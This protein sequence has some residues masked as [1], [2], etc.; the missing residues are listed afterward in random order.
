MASLGTKRRPAIVRVQTEPR[1][2]QL[3]ELCEANDIQVIIGLEPD[4]PEDITDIQHA[5]SPGTPA[6]SDRTAGRNDPC[7]CGSGAKFKRCCANSAPLRLA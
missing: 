4:K 3:L 2:R 6:R 7:P 1:A 5:L